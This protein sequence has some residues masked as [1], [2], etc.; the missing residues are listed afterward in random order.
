MFGS[1]GLI[2]E[3]S[4]SAKS[5]DDYFV[6]L[7]KVFPIISYRVYTQDRFGKIKTKTSSQVTQ[8]T[9]LDTCHVLLM[10]TVA[11]VIVPHFLAKIY[12]SYHFKKRRDETNKSK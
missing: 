9:A 5:T 11:R 3:A 4:V 10:P 6:Q 12:F 7:K 2:F 8:V 1:V